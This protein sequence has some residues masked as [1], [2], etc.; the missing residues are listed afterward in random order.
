MVCSLDVH[1]RNV[2]RQQH[3][4]IGVKLVAV[5]APQIFA[6]DQSALDEPR[7]ER[8]RPR[9]RVYDVDARVSKRRAEF[10]VQDILHATD[11]VVH[12][13]HWRIDNT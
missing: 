9:E 7:H 12:N 1:G 6:P 2:V 5:L 8:P 10:H 13:F 11:D 3:Y 4:L